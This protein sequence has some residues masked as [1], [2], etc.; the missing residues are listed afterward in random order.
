MSTPTLRLARMEE[1]DDIWAL[2]CRAVTHMNALGNPQWGEDY[3]T[4]D[5]YRADITRGELWAAEVEGTLAGVACINTD[6]APEYAAMPWT[7]TQPA[8]VIHRMAVDPAAQRSGIG[9]GFFRLAEAEALRRGLESLRID[10]Y[11]LNHRM[12]NLILSQGFCKVGEIHLHGRPL[13]YPCFE[14]SL[15]GGHPGR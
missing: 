2:V 10:T 1:L 11:S 4:I 5:F 9:R 7:T 13:T 6:E 8:V 12:Q 14:K 15:Q 3:P